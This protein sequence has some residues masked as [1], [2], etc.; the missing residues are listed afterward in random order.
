MSKGCDIDLNFVHQSADTW[1][2]SLKHAML[3]QEHV[4]R[5][6][7]YELH[8]L[9]GIQKTLTGGSKW[10]IYNYNLKCGSP[11]SASTPLKNSAEY[12]ILVKERSLPVAI[13]AKTM[14]PIKQNLLEEQQQNILKPLDLRLP[15]DEFISHVVNDFPEKGNL[16]NSFKTSIEA[17]SYIR[18]EKFFDPRDINLSLSIRNDVS[19]KTGDRIKISHIPYEVIDL[20]DPSLSLSNIDACSSFPSGL[21]ASSFSQDAKKD[22]THG[23]TKSRS[24]FGVGPDY[25]MP[26]SLNS[27]FSLQQSAILNGDF[28]NNNHLSAS[29]K[30]N[31]LDLYTVDVDASLCYSNDSMGPKLEN[32]LSVVSQMVDLRFPVDASLSSSISAKPKISHSV[33]NSDL[34]RDEDAANISLKNRK[35]RSREN[36][37]KEDAN[38]RVIIDLESVPDLSIDSGEA[39]FDLES[40]PK[41]E[42]VASQSKA[43][44]GPSCNGDQIDARRAR[45]K[46]DGETIIFSHPYKRQTTDEQ[47]KFSGSQKSDSNTDIQSSS[48]QTMQSGIECGHSNLSTS[49]DSG[50]APFGS[51][52]EESPSNNPDQRSSNSTESNNKYVDRLDQRAAESLVYISMKSRVFQQDCSVKEAS[53]NL[54][55]AHDSEPENSSE[56][57]ESIAL[58]LMESSPEDYSVQSMAFEA[59]ESEKKRDFGYSLK[60]GTRMKDFQKDI[61]PGLSTLARHEVC[62]DIN[63]M[64]S[65]IRSREYKKMRSKKANGGDRC[66]TVRSRRS[67]ANYRQRYYA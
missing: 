13:R 40:D 42:S 31:Y 44:D 15:A 62:E 60:R 23:T 53:N 59:C 17:K 41:D 11:Q 32:G 49:N 12:N 34:H 47:H 39:P 61:L 29:C 9:Y 35:D 7:V 37:T 38:S 4:F 36:L 26:A 3:N 2:E 50:K 56:S 65:V 28:F 46:T 22:L 57:Y 52:V 5:T 45:L 10:E 19:M 6:Q 14:Q 18:I 20:E 48:I 51:R 25:Q 66:R 67:G 43:P 58:K 16:L 21:S 64:A 24:L 8:R 30:S 55:N 1:K 33:Q 54:Q 27:G 63:I